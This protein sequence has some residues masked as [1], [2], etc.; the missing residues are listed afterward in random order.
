MY[1]NILTNLK[2]VV[3]YWKAV[4]NGACLVQKDNGGQSID[5][6][7]TVINL[8]SSS[9]KGKLLFSI[10]LWLQFMNFLYC[11]D[12]YNKWEYLTVLLIKNLL[13]GI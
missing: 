5:V 7:S 9:F 8:L 4:I 10:H 1:W 6:L 13:L 12:G 2:T 3:K 11:N